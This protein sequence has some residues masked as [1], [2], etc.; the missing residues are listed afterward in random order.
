VTSS[1]AYVLADDVILRDEAPYLQSDAR[2]LFLARQALTLYL[3]ASTFETLVFLTTARIPNQ[4]WE[5]YLDRCAV[6]GDV[7]KRPEFDGFWQAL[8]EMQVLRPSEACERSSRPHSNLGLKPSET[9]RIQPMS[10]P[11]RV[12]LVLTARCNLACKH[13]LRESS[14]LLR[15]EGELSTERVL[16]LMEELDSNGATSIQL[17]G[18]EV[19]VRKD[20]LEIVDYT[21]RLRSHVQFLTNGFVLRP[22]LI[23]VLAE[24]QAAKKQGFFVHL[25][26]DGGTPATNDW[27]RGARAYSRTLSAMESLSKAGVTVVVE[28]CLTPRNIGELELIANLCLDRG[29]SQL[30]FHPISY[31]GRAG[32]NPLFLPIEAVEQAASTVDALARQFA[33]AMTIEF[34]RQF[35]PHRRDADDS[36]LLPANTTGAGM[37]HMAIGADGK[38]CPC[39][40]SVGAP[41]LVMGDVQADS[42]SDIWRG[43]QWDLFRGGWTTD[44]LEGCRGCI[45]DGRCSTQA[46]RCYAVATGMGFYSPF[47]DCYANKHIL[48]G[49][50]GR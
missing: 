36:S 27:L 25:S 7:P 8:V 21:R 46:C 5:Y 35:S 48:W 49:G 23:E 20:I 3:S 1:T 16:R 10:F 19:T 34:G 6:N 14:P 41:S 31:T 4:A 2:F 15:G 47:R 11:T 18:G 9:C 22:G 40:E 44:E 12:S 32:C 28:S 43:P 42:T 30:T 45:F 13:C 26:L 38:V 50:D 24:V 17:S 37:F 39:I 33:P 29:V